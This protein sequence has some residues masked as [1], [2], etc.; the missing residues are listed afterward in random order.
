MERYGAL[1]V[2][3]VCTLYIELV[4][5]IETDEVYILSGVRVSLFFHKDVIYELPYL[6]Y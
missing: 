1:S 2:M 6:P 3:V 4:I 5:C